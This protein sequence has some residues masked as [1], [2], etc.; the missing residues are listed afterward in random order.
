[1]LYIKQFDFQP[2][3]ISIMGNG[4]QKANLAGTKRIKSSKLAPLKDG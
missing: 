1:V 2:L 4:Q 3:A